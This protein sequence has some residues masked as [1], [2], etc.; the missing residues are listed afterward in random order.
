MINPKSQP[1]YA[2]DPEVVEDSLTVESSKPL[3][4]T[5]A[6]PFAVYFLLFSTILFC[7]SFW[8]YRQIEPVLNSN[9]SLL[10]I[11]H[12][13]SNLS[14][15][16][17]KSLFQHFF[18]QANIDNSQLDSQVQ[19]ILRSDSRSWSLYAEVFD[20]Q[21]P[22][23]NR[24]WSFQPDGLGLF[25]SAQIRQDLQKLDPTNNSFLATSLPDGTIL[26]QN[27]Q[28]S[29]QTVTLYTLLSVPNKDVLIY[30]IAK[31]QIDLDKTKNLLP[32]LVSAIYWSFAGN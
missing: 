23:L 16:S 6:N 11:L 19:S 14:S 3:K 21:S 22:G 17:P 29:G 9:G 20:T 5:K 24:F 25:Q 18:H 31:N 10:N 2:D 7:L 1:K 30:T 26:R 8:T 12:L 15:F 13:P 4:K 28:E 27:Y 32:V